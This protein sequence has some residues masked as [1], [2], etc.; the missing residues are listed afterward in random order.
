MTE[1]QLKVIEML[2]KQKGVG[3][4][5]I[6]IDPRQVPSSLYPRLKSADPTVARLVIAYIKQ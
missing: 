3:G 4:R 6:H 5:P 1:N 2:F